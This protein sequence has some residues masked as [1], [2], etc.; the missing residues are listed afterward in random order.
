VNL[1]GVVLASLIGVALGLLGGGGSLLTV[2]VLVYALGVPA[3]QAV[4]MSL[5]IVGV[6]SLV[7]AWSHSRHGRVRLA[8]AVPFGLAAMAGAVAG[9]R[10]SRLLDPAVQ[11]VLLGVVMLAAS[12]SML[13]GAASETSAV[14]RPAR[15]RG[16]VLLAGAGVGLLTGALGIGGGFLIVPVLVLLVGLPMPQAVGTSLAIIAATAA[17]GIAGYA[18]TVAVPW[19][20]V[21]LFTAV[22]VGGSLVGARL[23][24]VVPAASLRRAFALFLFV[25][26]AYIL[27]ANRHAGP[28][29]AVAA[30]VR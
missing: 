5:P 7:A 10:V 20:F 12:L 15:P 19:S 24:G 9:A 11:L 17:A 2:P 14:P 29:P 25:A 21:I 13:R 1:F 30:A 23:S 6:A 22:T 4:A 18:G 26:G 28:T 16:L 27:Y 8:M 3:K